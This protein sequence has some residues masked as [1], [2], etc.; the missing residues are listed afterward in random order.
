MNIEFANY[1]QKREL[2]ATEEEKKYF[3]YCA[4]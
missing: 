1:G 2:N 3:R 4:R